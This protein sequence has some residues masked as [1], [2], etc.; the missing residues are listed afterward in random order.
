MDSPSDFKAPNSGNIDGHRVRR[1]SWW[2]VVSAL[3]VGLILGFG[4]LAVFN[5]IARPLALIILAIAIATALNPLVDRLDRRLP[6]FLAAILVYLVLFLVLIGIGTLIV[7]SL[8]SQATAL[9]NSLP[10]FIDQV[11]DFLEN[12]TFI[13]VE[14]LF[15]TAFDQ[16]GAFAIALVALPLGIASYLIDILLILFVALYWIILTPQIRGF[17]LSLFPIDRRNRLER[18]LNRMGAAMGGYV[19][20]VAIDGLIIAV[21]T[22]IGL[23]IIG[24]PFA[25]VLGIV[26][27][28]LEII[29]VVGPIIGGFLILSTALAH[30]PGLLLPTLIFVLVLQQ[31]ESNILV[32][33]IMKSQT[34]I[35]PLLVL[36]A[37]FIGSTIGGLIGALAAIPLVAAMRVLV[38]YMIAPAIRESTGAPP[39]NPEGELIED[40]DEKNIKEYPDPA[41][42]HQAPSD[43]ESDKQE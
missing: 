40:E 15:D 7:P 1:Y 26:A 35:S 17:F 29:P 14:T 2:W 8:L 25:L 37:V 30:D 23:S 6:R 11:Q 39:L 38:R 32:P 36:L 10:D 19:R 20:G 43:G 5:M 33:N 12:I 13:D 3:A 41:E 4:F 34:E 28:M 31:V 42:Q 24:V 22:T 16:F 27:G 21:L 18:V 9:I